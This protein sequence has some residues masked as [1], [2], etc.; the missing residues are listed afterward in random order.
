ML[1]CITATS[2]SISAATIAPFLSH[3]KCNVLAKQHQEQYYASTVTKAYHY[4]RCRLQLELRPHIRAIE[5]IY[6][7]HWLQAPGCILAVYIGW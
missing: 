7:G 6:N 5:R 2:S 4:F 3:L 1:Q